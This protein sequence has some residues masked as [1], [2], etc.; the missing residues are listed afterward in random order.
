MKTTVTELEGSRVR[1]EAEVSADAIERA[2]N[3]ATKELGKSLRLP[4]FRRGKVPPPVVLK[5]LGREVVLDEAVRSSLTAWYVEALRVSK[6]HAIGD[7]DLN[8]D[9]VPAQGEPLRFSFE[10]GVRP[11]AKLGDYK[12][13]EA[14]KPSTEP[15][16]G[17]VDAELDALRERQARLDTV[18]DAAANGDFV[19]MDYVGSIDGVEFEGGQGRDQMVELGSGRLIAGFEDG[20][21]G[22]SAGDERTLDLRFPD[23][24]PQ[25]ELAGKDAQ[26][27]VSVKEV[28]R[29]FLAEL[30]DA[31]AEEAAG[32][33]T[34]DELREDI[35]TKLREGLERQAE[36]RFREAAVDAVVE[37]ATIHVPEALVEA[38][39]KELWERLLHS[40]SHQGIGKDLYL[41]ISGR[42]EDE[43][44]DEAKPDAEQ[45]L[46]REAVL[47]A[48]AEAEG[49][50]AGD[51]DILDALQATA[52]REDMTPEKLRDR[53]DKAGRLGE[54]RE[55]IV[56]QRTVDFIAEHAT[57][58]DPDRAAARE[59]IWTPD[60]D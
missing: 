55:D 29:K 43:M 23:E 18:E 41:Q 59:K 37:N 16:D 48:V 30:D 52:A 44:L 51:G 9:D 7:P 19:V 17:A 49:I 42:T 8:L 14:A 6:I 20:L 47:V 39:A 50:E 36:A 35:A 28:K 4:G 31:F 21:I 26:F 25:P 22:A 56:Q 3:K 5:R 32:F 27:A 40:L 15:E 38:R 53:L 33:D 13:V 54:L 46:K 45:G 10:I 11:T 2:V 1:V 60:K 57:A 34:L 58:I 12:G 24:Y